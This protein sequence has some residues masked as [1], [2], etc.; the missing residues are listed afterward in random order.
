MKKHLITI[1]LVILGFYVSAQT[2]TL[3]LS[4]ADAS[5]LPNMKPSGAH[6]KV[7]RVYGQNL[8]TEYY[9]KSG[10][11]T[12]PLSPFL[13]SLHFNIIS[14]YVDPSTG[15][16]A[17]GYWT[18]EKVYSALINTIDF[19]KSMD[20]L[21]S[22]ADIFK[23]DSTRIA[24]DSVRLEDY[25]ATVVTALNSKFNNPTGTTTQYL[26]G[27]GSSVS[28]QWLTDSTLMVV[29]QRFVSKDSIYNNPTWIGYLDYSTKL[30][31]KPN[32]SVYETTSHAAS[33]FYPLANPNGFISSVPAQSFA[34][35]TAKPTNL[36][37]YGITDA[38]PLSGNPSSFLTG[39]TSGQITTALAF[40]PVTNAR[41]LTINGTT[42]DLSANRSFS[43][44]TVTSIGLSSTDF[45]VSG[46]PVTS[47]GNITANLTT[48]GIAAGTYGILTIDSKGRATLGKRQEPYTGTT[49][50]SGTY[51][52]TYATAYAVEPN[53]I[54]SQKG[55]TPT[56]TILL[57]SSSATGFTVTANNRVEVL[58]LL[59]TYPTLNGA[60]VNVLVTEK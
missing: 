8:Q 26:N 21:V 10:V 40:T 35:L 22:A 54:I 57:T 13:A 55:G 47:S 32:L 49:S 30:S 34:S 42:L 4:I 46:T 12:S 37:G 41:A 24:L 1:F 11:P 31:N 58:G 14:T 16:V 52:V 7:D 17:E 48:T 45:S 5:M 38:Y 51:T 28:F 50:G 19:S 53:V 59:P 6:F 25:K 2:P 56:N 27:Q 43:V 23:S 44:G 3:T 39:I 33:T 20:H 29:T 9:F 15:L 18:T 60:I 36:S